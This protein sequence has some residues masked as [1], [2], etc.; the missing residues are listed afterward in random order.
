MKYFLIGL[1]RLIIIS[2][3][4]IPFL[5]ITIIQFIGGAEGKDILLYKFLKLL[6]G[7]K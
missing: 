1:F 3:F 6:E 4:T 2:I 7:E 5:M